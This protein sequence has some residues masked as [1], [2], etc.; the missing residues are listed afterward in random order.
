MLGMPPSYLEVVRQ[1]GG[2]LVD[3]RRQRE[4]VKEPLKVLAER[5][6]ELRGAGSREVEPRQSLAV[7]RGTDG[8]VHAISKSVHREVGCPVP[9]QLNDVAYHLEPS[10]E[11]APHTDERCVEISENL[12][13]ERGKDAERAVG[14]STRHWAQYE[15][16]PT[17]RNDNTCCLSVGKRR[18]DDECHI[19]VPSSKAPPV[20]RGGMGVSQYISYSVSTNARWLTKSI[21]P[22]PL[23]AV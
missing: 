20:G 7:E 14:E 23:L 1:D 10:K 5:N 11:M 9:D 19:E 2:N 3:D 17:S 21:H 22:E 15:T 18:P 6:Q 12:V 8:I 16:Q 4:L 13:E